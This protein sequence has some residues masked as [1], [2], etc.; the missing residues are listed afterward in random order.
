M[1]PAPPKH[2]SGTPRMTREQTGVPGTYPT[3][4]WICSWNACA[5]QQRENAAQGINSS[6]KKFFISTWEAPRE[7]AE[8]RISKPNSH[9]HDFDRLWICTYGTWIIVNLR[10]LWHES[11]KSCSV[12]F[13]EQNMR[14]FTFLFATRKL[15]AYSNVKFVMLNLHNNFHLTARCKKIT[16]KHLPDLT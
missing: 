1:T 12:C 2:R 9:L 8:K 14:K 16:I 11:V 15:H 10:Q 13:W 5:D 3:P 7:N 6:T 4:T